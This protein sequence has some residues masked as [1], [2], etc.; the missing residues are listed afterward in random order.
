MEDEKQREANYPTIYLPQLYHPPWAEF[1]ITH[2]QILS[3]SDRF[4]NGIQW[5]S[6]VG[7]VLGVSLI[8]K[9]LG[10]DRKTQIFASVLATTIPMGILQASSTQN[11]FVVS[12]WLVCFVVYA[13]RIATNISERGS[14][15]IV[16]WGPALGAG[17]SLGLALMTK[18]SAYIYSAPFVVWLMLIMVK[19]NPSK[20]LLAGFVMGSLV[21]LLNSG[22]FLRNTHLFGSPLSSGGESYMN[23]VYSPRGFISN[24]ARNISLHI[25][26]LFTTI[27]VAA[28]KMILR[29]HDALGIAA[30]DPRT[31]AW[32]GDTEFKVNR[33][34]TVEDFAG[35]PLHALLII[36]SVAAFV[37]HKALRVQQNVVGYL[38]SACATFMLF[39]VLLK[40]QP[41][42]SRLH[43]PLFVLFAPLVAIIISQWRTHLV[44][45]IMAVLLIGS[46]PWV[47]A[48]QTR[49]LVPVFKQHKSI[50]VESRLDQYFQR[51]GRPLR[52]PY[53]GA[54]AFLQERNLHDIGL[55]LPYDPFEYQLWVILKQGRTDVRL[56]HIEVE[57]VSS[58]AAPLD[59]TTQFLPEA[60]IRVRRG[61]EQPRSELRMGERLHTRMWSQ[62]PVEVYFWEP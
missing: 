62:D 56:E 4:A 47:L 23:E 26:T 36:V 50:L 28:E 27:N 21:L 41:W 32:M 54:A 33:M 25:G 52:E 15:D 46:L 51:A 42:H 57:N 34:D 53:L 11:D 37:F 30:N 1:A 38:V 55:I 10:A 16:A 43:L 2:L 58:A 24:V 12:F 44:T 17:A 45:Y 7:S 8:A 60:G 49:S 61:N 48:N 35:N 59:S 18:G 14:Q 40:W 39:N 5:L 19:R 31:S 20:A 9:L 29:L 6:M 22:H 3:N 13:L